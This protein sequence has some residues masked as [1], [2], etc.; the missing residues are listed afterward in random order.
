[1]EIHSEILQR[2]ILAVILLQAAFLQ[3]GCYVAGA[4]A[5]G[6]AGAAVGEK[7][8]EKDEEDD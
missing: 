8:A 6:A 5:G 4:A 3:T 1:M 2:V 7:I